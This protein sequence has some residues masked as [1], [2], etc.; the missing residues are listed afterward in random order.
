[1]RGWLGRWALTRRTGSVVVRRMVRVSSP[2]SSMVMV[3][4]ATWTVTVR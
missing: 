1:M 3:C 2:P 4:P